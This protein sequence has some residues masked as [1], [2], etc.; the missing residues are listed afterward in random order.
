MQ[1]STIPD[2]LSGGL[3][4]LTLA[5]I[6]AVGFAA[7]LSRGFSGFGAA[8]IFMP[9]ASSVIGPRVAAP[10]LLIVDAVAALS[11]LPDAWRT[12]DKARVFVMALGGV[13]GIP[14]GTAALVAFDQI[15]VRWFISAIVCA[16]LLLLVSGWRYHGR[17]SST[18]TILVGALSGIFSGSS[19]AGGPPVIAYW[20]GSHEPRD[21]I[22]ANIVAYFAVATVVTIVSYGFSGL[23][24]WRL[25]PLCVSVGVAYAL[26]LQLGARLFRRTGE[27]GFRWVSYVLIAGAGIGS[28]PALDHI[29]R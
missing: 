1:I 2:A 20:L 17:P 13:L 5:F 3:P 6:G 29:L 24:A 22:R 10:V 26:G 28:L 8:L 19:G 16:L 25:L 12:A 18:A 15:T 23:F 4:A 7:G 27:A 14:L 9:M 21:F 11:L